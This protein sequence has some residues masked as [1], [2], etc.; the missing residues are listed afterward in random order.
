MCRKLEK[1]FLGKVPCN[2][3]SYFSTKCI[4]DHV[5]HCLLDDLKFC[6]MYDECELNNTGMFVNSTLEKRPNM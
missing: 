4:G 3:L 2:A 5:M 6:C 1:S